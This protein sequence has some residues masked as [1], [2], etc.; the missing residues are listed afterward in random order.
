MYLTFINLEVLG[1]TFF[2]QWDKSEWEETSRKSFKT[3]M[4]EIEYSFVEFNRKL[5]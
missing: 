4:K 5:L 3:E 2:P 1:D